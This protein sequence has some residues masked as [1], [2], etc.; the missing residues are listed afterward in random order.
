MV[1]LIKVEAYKLYKEKQFRFIT[2]AIISFLLYTFFAVERTG[3]QTMEGMVVSGTTDSIFMIYFIGV[4]A[5]IVFTID[6]ANKT[7]KNFLPQSNLK[8]VFVAK[9]IV[10]LCGALMLL[11]LWYAI[12]VICAI[13]LSGDYNSAVLAPL[14]NRF[15]VHYSLIMFHSGFIILASV[16]SRNRA[17]ATSFT[18]I[19]WMLYAFIPLNNRLFYDMIVANYRWRNSLNIILCLGF[20]S[21]YII[22]AIVAFGVAERQEVRV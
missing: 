4:V 17:V 18:V 5:A 14:L 21:V 12:V 2:L 10:V 1:D 16:I 19:G 7:F 15:I 9:L 20:I 6:Y 13:V 22:F 3:N 8:K 11:L